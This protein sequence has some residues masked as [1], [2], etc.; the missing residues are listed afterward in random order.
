MS[1]TIAPTVGVWSSTGGR[2]DIW[3]ISPSAG[4]LAVTK[5][6]LDAAVHSALPAA[7]SY[8]VSALSVEVRDVFMTGCGG[9]AI[10]KLTVGGPI[11]A[12]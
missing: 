1:K 4:K 7:T 5:A 2:T 12:P 8:T 11:T 3:E 9:T 10:A 6:Q